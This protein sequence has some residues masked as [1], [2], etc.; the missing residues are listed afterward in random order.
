M[1]NAEPINNTRQRNADKR[2]SRVLSIG[3]SSS[4]FTL[5]DVDSLLLHWLLGYWSAAAVVIRAADSNRS[6]GRDQC[7]ITD[8][9]FRHIV[10]IVEAAAHLDH[11]WSEWPRR[12]RQA[13]S[14]PT[15]SLDGLMKMASRR[16]RN[17]DLISSEI[18]RSHLIG[19]RLFHRPA[20]HYRQI[21]S[22]DR[23]IM[24]NC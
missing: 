1:E 24:I 8:C 5:V 19:Q 7:N 13:A 20:E 14:T 18:Q 12:R 10:T 9:F 2:S 15:E 6:D 21:D 11:E 17:G 16:R 4:S 22:H 3:T 23:E